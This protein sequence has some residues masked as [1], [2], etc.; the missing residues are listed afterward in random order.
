MVKQKPERKYHTEE[1]SAKNVKLRGKDPIQR[2]ALRKTL[3]LL[4]ST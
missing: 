1:K 3:K 4:L 2:E